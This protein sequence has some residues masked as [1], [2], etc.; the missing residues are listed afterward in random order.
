MGH[1]TSKFPFVIY[2]VYFCVFWQNSFSRDKIVFFSENA[3]KESELV[4]KEI[5]RPT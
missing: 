4:L 3:L 2:L 5:A 1:T